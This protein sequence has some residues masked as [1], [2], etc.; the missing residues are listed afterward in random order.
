MFALFK[1]GYF[2]RHEGAIGL[3]LRHW[4]SR[5]IAQLR[6]QRGFVDGNRPNDHPCNENHTFVRRKSSRDVDRTRSLS[7]QVSRR[8]WPRTQQQRQQQPPT[9]QN[10]RHRRIWLDGM[11][12]LILEFSQGERI[13][14][15][16]LHSFSLFAFPFSLIFS[17]LSATFWLT[18]SPRTLILPLSHLQAQHS[19]WRRRTHS[20]IPSSR[21]SYLITHLCSVTV[22]AVSFTLH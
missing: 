4:F 19:N 16:P 7:G 3:P 18:V 6:M 14:L 15:F 2:S 9:V 8:P 22:C 1:Q 17:L 13:P 10:L 11:M 5:C 21:N 20:R 12:G